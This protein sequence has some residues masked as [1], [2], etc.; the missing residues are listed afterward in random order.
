MISFS[1]LVQNGGSRRNNGDG[2]EETRELL[3]EFSSRPTSTP[4]A[5]VNNDRGMQTLFSFSLSP[6][7]ASMW[8]SSP[9]EETN[10]ATW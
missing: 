2:G 3:S 5:D 1:D 6:P 7:S 4:I 9:C 8:Q 10:S